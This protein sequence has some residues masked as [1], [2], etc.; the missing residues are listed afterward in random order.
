MERVKQLIKGKRSSNRDTN[1]RHNRARVFFVFVSFIPGFIGGARP[2]AIFIVS[3]NVHNTQKYLC[4]FCAF[5]STISVL[6]LRAVPI[7]VVPAEWIPN[8]T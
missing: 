7:V 4:F 5:D 8:R 6:L 1:K 2:K 3:T